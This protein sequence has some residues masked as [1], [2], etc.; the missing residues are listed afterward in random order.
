MLGYQTL[1]MSDLDLT[2][3]SSA[4]SAITSINNA[5]ETVSFIEVNLELIIIR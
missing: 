4:D 1:E 3:Q 5:I 2:S